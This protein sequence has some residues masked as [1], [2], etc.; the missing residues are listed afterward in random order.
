[1]LDLLGQVWRLCAPEWRRG[2][3]APHACTRTPAV[4]IAPGAG[5][6][7]ASLQ[8]TTLTDLMLSRTT[9]QLRAPTPACT[10]LHRPAAA[11][12]PV[13]SHC[14]PSRCAALAALLCA[15]RHLPPHEPHAPPTLLSA[16]SAE[17]K[18]A[19]L[20][21]LLREVLPQEQP[22]IVFTCGWRSWGLRG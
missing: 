18:P 5:R 7:D 3:G 12:I 4:C 13:S 8:H 17:D 20:L 16:R 19:A 6:E 9:V 15:G 22:T 11:V 14:C 2:G 1:M 21:Y 10:L